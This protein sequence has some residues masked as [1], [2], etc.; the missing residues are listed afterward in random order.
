MV[1]SLIKHVTY[2]EMLTC[3][4]RRLLFY[5]VCTLGYV[6]TNSFYQ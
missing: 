3:V 1:H 6:T 2:C 5:S 4:C